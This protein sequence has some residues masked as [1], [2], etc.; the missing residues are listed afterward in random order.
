MQDD[1][2]I[3]GRLH[4]RAFA[5]QFAAQGDA[6]GQIAVMADREAAGVELGK[7][8]LH[9]AQDGLAGR[10]IAHMPDCGGAGQAIDHLASGEGVADEAEAPLGMKPLA[11]V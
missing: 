3:G 4:H 11:V 7:Q 8:R 9:V 1:F 6:V 10:R 5:Y 2:R